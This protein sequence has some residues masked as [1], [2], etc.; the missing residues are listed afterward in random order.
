[1][2]KTI[3]TI[4]KCLRCG[5]QILWIVEPDQEP[6]WQSS[7]TYACRD[8]G[9]HHLFDGRYLSR[10]YPSTGPVVD[11]SDTEARIWQSRAR[12]ICRRGLSREVE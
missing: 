1:M 2:T 12:G 4:L 5:G 11:V 10:R 3:E 6:P 9:E 7:T 8:C